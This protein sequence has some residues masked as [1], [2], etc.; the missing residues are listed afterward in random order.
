MGGI[1]STI[2]LVY[3]FFFLFVF[4]IVVAV[5]FSRYW[6]VGTVFVEDLN[7]KRWSLSS[8]SAGPGRPDEQVLGS[9]EGG[10]DRERERERRVM[11][12]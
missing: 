1:T 4:L 12:L 5:Y 8:A 7:N 10:K 9:Q 3:L 2:R 6:S 11:G